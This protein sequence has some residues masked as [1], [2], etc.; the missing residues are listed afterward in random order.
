MKTRA[1]LIGLTLGFLAGCESVPAPAPGTAAL[2]LMVVAEPKTG[3]VAAN[4]HVSV[5]DSATATGYGPSGGSGGDFERV[6]YPALSE[7]VV[8]LE[9][10][11]STKAAN[12]DHPS[13]PVEIDPQKPATFLTGAV[14]VGQ[15]LVIHNGGSRAANVYSVSDG[16]DFDLGS[17]PPGG[18]VRY[19]VRSPGL[20]E[21]LSDSIADP[22]AT[23]YAVPT[24][25]F[26]LAR[27]GQTVAFTDLPP[28]RY[29]VV[30][31]HPRLPG[32]QATVT[33]LANQIASATIKV[34]VN[35]LP[36]VEP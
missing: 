15:P 17:L 22:V 8:W 30:S 10:I 20:I 2:R 16:N 25:W 29:R 27:S 18:T 12:P 23:I 24:P 5:Y 26:R 33:L 11:D 3:A 32:H 21:I 36:I 6:D 7:I 19:T 34:G 1:L 31:W 9:P 14:C 13:T 4:T 28:G 35:G